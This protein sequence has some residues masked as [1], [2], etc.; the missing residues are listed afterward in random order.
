MKVRAL[1]SCMLPRVPEEAEEIHYRGMATV[2][3]EVRN[4]VETWVYLHC[5]YYW[6][7]AGGD[8]E[9][10]WVDDGGDH[11]QETDAYLDCLSGIHVYFL[12]AF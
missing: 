8:P 4:D 11:S 10:G 3:V 12:V 2:D 7:P 6:T 1:I 5:R 9:A